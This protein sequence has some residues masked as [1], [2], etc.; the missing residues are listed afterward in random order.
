MKFCPQCGSEVN[1]GVKFCATCGFQIGS[2]QETPPPPNEPEPVKQVQEPVYDQAKQAKSAFT[3]AVS[4]KTNL[5]QRVIN[6]LTKPKQ[7]WIVIE[8]EQPNTINLL[9]GYALVLALI[10]AI[11]V[12]IKWGIIGNTIWGVTSRS[13][14]MG[15]MQALI[16]LIGAGI[17]VYLFAWVIDLLAPSFESGKNMGKSLQLATYANTP[18][19]VLG[20][21]NLVGV[22]GSLVIF[23]GAIYSIYLLYIGIPILK[24]TP[25]DKVTG[26]LVI[27]IIALIVIYFVVAMILGL[28]F[29]LFFINGGGLRG[30]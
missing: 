17:G 14:S 9:V 26:Y 2:P 30:F 27:S 23:L 8:S 3:D 18:I 21:L 25:A 6:I 7:E 16:Q 4:G 15:I 12:F 29:G 13:I 11:A 5:V 19:W 10:P 28:F 1:E 22:L 24:K 20:I